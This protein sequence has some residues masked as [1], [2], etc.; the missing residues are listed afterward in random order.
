[1]SDLVD[2]ITRA[3]EVEIEDLLKAVLRR[4][5]EL[6]P[7]RELSVISAQRNSDKNAQLDSIVEMLQRMKTQT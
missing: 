6:F 7:D 1:M 2:E 3:D 4:C 5:E